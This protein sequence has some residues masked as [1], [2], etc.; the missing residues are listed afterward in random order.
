M[1]I[2]ISMIRQNL[3]GSESAGGRSL[4]EVALFSPQPQGF[5]LWDTSGMASQV[6]VGWVLV[7]VIVVGWVCLSVKTIRN[8]RAHLRS[9]IVLT[10][11]C[12]GSVG[13]AS[14]ALG[15]CTAA[16]AVH[17]ALLVAAR[18][19][20]RLAGQA[21]RERL[22]RADR[23]PCHEVAADVRDEITGGVR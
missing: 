15:C 3:E 18:E 14:L 1:L 12:A 22:D 19:R 7:A 8:H 21:E 16:Y 11:L 6:Y 20:G 5:F 10:V 23:R 13:V 4:R 2:Y 9:W 17:D